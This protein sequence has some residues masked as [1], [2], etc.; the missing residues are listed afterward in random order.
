MNLAV[1]GHLGSIGKRRFHILQDMG[2]KVTGYDKGD[3]IS[4]TALRQFDAAF[5]C[6]PTQEHLTHVISCINAPLPFFC[7]KPLCTTAVDA[8]YLGNI[9]LKTDIIN[10]VACNIRFTEEFKYIQSALVNIGKPLYA[11]AEFGYYLPYWRTG[12][13][14]TY[15]SAYKT[16]GGGVLLDAIH[17]FDYLFELFGNLGAHSTLL[18]RAENTGELEIDV[19]DTAT[20]TIMARNAPMIF[21]HL[22]YL[23]R[24]YSRKF[25]CVGTKGRV[26]TTFN[27]QDNNTMYRHEMTHFLECVKAKKDTC[28]PIYKHLRVFDFV[29]LI[30]NKA[31]DIGNNPNQI[32]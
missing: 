14:R 18:F 7:E 25:V 21:V 17:E 12:D 20:V 22:D 28:N 27:V 30:R 23:Q 3:K 24:A 13:Y 8:H 32:N 26:E 9:I 31:H 4:P 2:H 15:Y 16:S 5:I 11:F 19:E 1:I 29:T 10:M 6:S